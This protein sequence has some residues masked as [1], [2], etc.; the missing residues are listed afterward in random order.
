MCPEIS[1]RLDAILVR[2]VGAPKLG[3]LRTRSSLY[4]YAPACAIGCEVGTMTQYYPVASTPEAPIGCSH[5]PEEHYTYAAREVSGF[6]GV[7]N[8]EENVAEP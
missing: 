3:V 1:M 6:Q 2:H 4:V 7:R 5:D 8:T